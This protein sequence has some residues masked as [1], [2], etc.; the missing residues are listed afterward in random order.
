[1][2]QIRAVI[3][4]FI[5]TLANVHSYSL[6][7]SMNTLRDAL[8]GVGFNCEKQQFI[9][10]YKKAHEKYR[11]VRYGELREVTN[12]V[13]VAETLC[14][15]GHDVQVDD[16]RMKE[17]LN[18]FFQDFVDSLE[19]R[20]CAE[21]L[22]EKISQTCKLALVSNFTYAP[23]VYASL[24]KLGINRFFNVV[25]VSEENGWRKPHQKIFQDTLRQ[26]QVTA[27]EAIYIGD[28]P[29]EDIKGAL[30]AGLKTIFVSSQFYN[31]NDL[32][33][34]KQEP[35]IIVD[36]LEQIYQNLPKILI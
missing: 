24:R 28:S 8:L 17:A 30:Q 3:T 16:S 14:D 23:A 33:N 36:N 19:L 1:M 12:A 7:A 31:L 11:I 27:E 9:A 5:G 29:M 18:V 6:D 2:P 10:A 22:L 32:Q 15:L 4:D 25:I 34:S 13:W 20:P 35:H 21:A 26:M